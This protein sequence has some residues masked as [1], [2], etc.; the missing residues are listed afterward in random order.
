VFT[1]LTGWGH[2]PKVFVLPS[3]VFDACHANSKIPAMI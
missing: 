1:L 3:L 2:E